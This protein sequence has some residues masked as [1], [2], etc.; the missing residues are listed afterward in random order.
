EVH[1]VESGGGLAKPEESL[2][3][4]Y[5]ASAGFTFSSYYMNCVRQAPGNRLEW[6]R[7]VNPNGGSTYLTDSGKGRFT[8]PRDNAK[9]TLHLQMNRLKTENTAMYYCTQ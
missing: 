2:R 8:I 1:L 5:A 3:L 6:V 9:N 7:Q 4:S